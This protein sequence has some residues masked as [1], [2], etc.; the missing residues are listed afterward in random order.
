MWLYIQFLYYFF[1][2]IIIIIICLLL[3]TS[4]RAALMHRSAVTA[5][6][7]VG[8]SPVKAGVEMPTKSERF[9]TLSFHLRAFED[10]S[11]NKRDVGRKALNICCIIA[12]LENQFKNT[13]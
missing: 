11:A 3:G 6:T 7:A 5:G 8:R 2:F 4:T 10:C 1:L 9:F 12:T 13:N